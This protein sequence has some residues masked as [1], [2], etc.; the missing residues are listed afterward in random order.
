MG[1]DSIFLRGDVAKCNATEN[2]ESD[3][4]FADYEVRRLPGVARRQV[5]FFAS[6]K[7]VTK[8]RRTAD[9]A[10]RCATGSRKNAAQ[11]RKRNNSPSLRSV[12][13]QISLLI[14]FAQHFYGSV[15]AERVYCIELTMLT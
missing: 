13:K 3:P 10:L 1:S 15:E 2:I 9:T 14:C 5:T 12:L 7:K 11:N 6:P 4:F 8:E